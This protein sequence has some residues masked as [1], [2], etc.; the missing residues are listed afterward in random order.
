MQVFKLLGKSMMAG[1][2]WEPLPV[3]IESGTKKYIQKLASE[4]DFN[5]YTLI[6][7][8]E[9]QTGFASSHEKLSSKY[10]IASILFQVFS[11]SENSRDIAAILEIS[12]DLYLYYGQKDGLI[13]YDGDLA[14]SMQDVLDRLNSHIALYGPFE[15]L[16]A[17]ESLGIE[18][19]TNATFETILGNSL[20]TIRRMVE[21]S[22]ARV[23]PCF[24]DKR[25]RNAY[26]ATGFLT[27][28]LFAASFRGLIVYQANEA[29]ARLQ[30]EQERISKAME[31]NAPKPIYQTLPTSSEM[32]GACLSL[33][34]ANDLIFPNWSLVAIECS[35]TG[36]VANLTKGEEGR[37]EDV[38]SRYPD[39]TINLATN[40][41]TIK[42]RQNIA[43]NYAGKII[44]PSMG[45]VYLNSDKAI[46]Y[47]IE[48]KYKQA[49]A[50]ANLPGQDLI[51]KKVAELDWVVDKTPFTPDRVID[52]IDN[53]GLRISKITKIFGLNG[54]T[55]TLEGTQYAQQ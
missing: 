9:A 42:I 35:S 23:R 13:L 36:V 55:W 41:A 52:L 51:T 3:E 27:V 48:I 37:Y 53:S 24:L 25:R 34:N 18:N 19:S 10:S 32:V 2:N 40:A 17:P 39:S 30:L 26:I 6:K 15:V 49:S 14:G 44:L 33:I 50:S 22:Q 5:L 7:G 20:F 21:L 46:S 45:D 28:I 47:G 12:T 43:A 54:S 38:I 11:A 1:L 16:Y 29:A 8:I 31:E 4:Q